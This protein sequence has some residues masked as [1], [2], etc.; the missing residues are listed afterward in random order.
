MWHVV[1]PLEMAVLL[2]PV[3]PVGR[4]PTHRHP[5]HVHTPDPCLQLV[6]VLDLRPERLHLLVY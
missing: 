6:N 5:A 3:H 1:R 4:A 2:L